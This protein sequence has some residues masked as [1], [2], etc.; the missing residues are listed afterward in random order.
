MNEPVYKP[1]SHKYRE[2]QKE[3]A[4]AAEHEA[5]V[6]KVV[7]SS[8]KTK[9]N[10]VRKFADIFISE[11]V[12]NVKSY[13]FMD[14]LVPSIKKA[15]YDIVTTGID[16]IL[17]GGAARSNNGNNGIKVSYRNYYDQRNSPSGPSPRNSDNQPVKNGFA[18]E[19]II[20]NTR[21]E[22]EA[23]KQQ[24]QDTIAR[25][26]VV[27]VADMYDM[28]DLPAPFTSQKYGWM[29]ISNSEIK[30]ELSGYILKLPRAV[31]LDD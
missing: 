13:I 9:Q 5:R 4:K 21:G 11:D 7:K 23:A 24:M 31:P 10:T 27:T 15:I 28:A 20:F 18:Y 12:K 1:N 26:G 14:V 3:L 17:Y 30:R 19:D 2:Q 29:D 8:A 22:A 6:K 25:Y 16:K